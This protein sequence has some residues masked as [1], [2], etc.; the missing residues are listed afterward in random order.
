MPDI[1]VSGAFIAKNEILRRLLHKG[2]P[3]GL[4]LF[5]PTSNL[6]G[7]R[8]EIITLTSGWNHK[9]NKNA[10]TGTVIETVKINQTAEITQDILD[11]ASGFDI[12]YS[13]D[14]FER[15]TFGAKGQAKPI[16]HEWNLTVTP[17][18]GDKSALVETFSL[19]DSNYVVLTDDTNY[20]I[21]Y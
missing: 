7:G 3:I 10:E 2:T 9:Q 21:G 20:L 8:E 14:T 12:L 15:Y 1:N 19:T 13:D 5:G 6:F 17:S 16:S 4:R 18:L 11:R